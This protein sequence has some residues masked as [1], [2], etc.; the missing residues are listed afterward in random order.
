[1]RAR[2]GLVRRDRCR[3][4]SRCRRGPA[5]RAHGGPPARRGT[6]LAIRRTPAGDSGPRSA[7]ASTAGRGAQPDDGDVR[8]R[9]RGTAL[10]DVDH[11]RRRADDVP[12]RRRQ[13]VHQRGRLAARASRRRPPRREARERSARSRPR[14]RRRNRASPADPLG[15]LAAHGRLA[16]AHQPGQHDVPDLVAHADSLAHG[17]R[18]SPGRTAPTLHSPPVTTSQP[19]GPVPAPAACRRTV[20]SAHHESAA[21]RV[22]AL[23]QAKRP[24]LVVHH[25]GSTAVPGLP[26]KGVLDLGIHAEPDEI[27]GITARPVRPR[28]RSADRRRSVA[29]DPA[30]ARRLA[31]RSRARSSTST[32]TSSRT[33][34]EFEARSRV[35]RCAPRRPGS[36][37]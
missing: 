14:C 19:I 9:Q 16:G 12:L 15:Q 17:A 3:R 4:R 21:A 30:D 35:P 32:A 33:A 20:G 7:S 25:T 23:I 18:P 13:R 26:G 36:D 28:L 5:E 6:P 37:G 11:A 10:R 22:I 27:P 31:S 8:R 34:A 1:M 2:H 24:D 29:A